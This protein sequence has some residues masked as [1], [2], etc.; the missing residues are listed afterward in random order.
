MVGEAID[1][2]CSLHGDMRDAVGNANLTIPRR[3]NGRE[4]GSARS[5]TVV[6]EMR[7]PCGRVPQLGISSARHKFAALGAMLD[8]WRVLENQSAFHRATMASV[9]FGIRISAG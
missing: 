5:L 6:G 9:C 1:G 3:C 8:A 4:Q 7:G 2:G